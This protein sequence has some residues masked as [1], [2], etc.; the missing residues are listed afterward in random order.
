MSHGALGGPPRG[1]AP[2][3]PGAGGGPLQDRYPAQVVRGW[4]SGPMDPAGE[5][6]KVLAEEEASRTSTRRDI[7]MTYP[8]RL[9]VA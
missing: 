4:R 8:D 3:R 7:C 6:K 9:D 2:S 5:C 1:A